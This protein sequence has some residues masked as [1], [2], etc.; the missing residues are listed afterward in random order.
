MQTLFLF[1]AYYLYCIYFFNKK[2]S[3]IR[4]YS[5]SIIVEYKKNI[6]INHLNSTW[7]RLRDELEILNN[8]FFCNPKM[9]SDVLSC[10]TKFR[11]CYFSMQVNNKA[12]WNHAWVYENF[13]LSNSRILFITLPIFSTRFYTLFQRAEGGGDG[14]KK[15]KREKNKVFIRKEIF[16][17]IILIFF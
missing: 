12:T 14:I 11:K 17:I 16:K 7:D 6:A 4:L 10:R 3:R 8:D 13:M 9:L 5:S 1:S 15:Y 2:L